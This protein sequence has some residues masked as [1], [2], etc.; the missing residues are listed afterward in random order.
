MILL[1][2][3]DLYTP[4]IIPHWELYREATK[5]MADYI[6]ALDAPIDLESQTF[7]DFV[8]NWGDKYRV[9]G[10]ADTAA[11]EAVYN[12]AEQY[13]ALRELLDLAGG[14]FDPYEKSR[15][16]RQLVPN[17]RQ[18]FGIEESRMQHGV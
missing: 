9:I 12:N 14:N 5:E 8:V 10:A 1:I 17:V 3:F 6:Q 11:R 13:L 7:R 18:Y 16:L 15:E 4:E 2:D